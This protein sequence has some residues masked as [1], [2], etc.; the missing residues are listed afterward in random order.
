MCGGQ[1]TPI[2]RLLNRASRASHCQNILSLVSDSLLRT[3]GNRLAYQDFAPRLVNR[4]ISV[5]KMSSS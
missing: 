1:V 4:E 2:G 5:E 3:W